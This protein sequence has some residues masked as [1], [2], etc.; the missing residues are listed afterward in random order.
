MKHEE[1]KEERKA[2]DY[3]LKVNGGKKKREK[4]S[5][6]LI[7]QSFFSIFILEHFFGGG[8]RYSAVKTVQ[9]LK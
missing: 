4:P 5:E 7:F 6:A 9:Y 1:S 3:E 8:G 2:L